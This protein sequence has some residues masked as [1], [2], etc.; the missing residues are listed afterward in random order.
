MPIAAVYE[1][2][3]PPGREDHVGTSREI[4][5]VQTKAVSECVRGTADG[6]L[7]LGVTAANSGHDRRAALTRD[8]VHSAACPEP[9]KLCAN[10][11]AWLSPGTF[12]GT[13][14]SDNAQQ[15]L[16]FQAKRG[17][18]GMQ[19][20]TYRQFAPDCAPSPASPACAGKQ[21]A[22]LRVCGDSDASP[23]QPRRRRSLA[24][25]DAG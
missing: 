24:L 14:V 11:E 25:S 21:A 7:R 15:K 22:M 5:P 20:M 3:L 12:F 9:T 18:W 4:A 1:D 19:S 23:I 16:N 6:K 10:S 13:S 17:T 8:D 2:N